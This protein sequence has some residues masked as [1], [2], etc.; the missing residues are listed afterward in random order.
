[1]SQH[2]SLTEIEQ[3]V[4]RHRLQTEEREERLESSSGEL[5]KAMEQTAWSR[6]G[7]NRILE[8]W[9]TRVTIVH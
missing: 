3:K 9:N 7:M 4:E 2:T 5:A 8:K 6:C 1:M